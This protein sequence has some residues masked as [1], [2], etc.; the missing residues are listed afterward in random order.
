MSNLLR[1]KTHRKRRLEEIEAV[2][3]KRIIK[4][5]LREAQAAGAGICFL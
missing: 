2:G 5:E 3:S 4:N 1:S